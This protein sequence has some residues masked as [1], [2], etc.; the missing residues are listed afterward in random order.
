MRARGKPK[1]TW[2]DG[3]A[4]H[5]PTLRPHPYVEEVRLPD[6]LVEAYMVRLAPGGLFTLRQPMCRDARFDLYYVRHEF[7]Y[8]VAQPWQA[9]NLPS[10]HPR[11]TM[12]VYAGQVRVTEVGRKGDTLRLSRHSFIIDTVRYITTNLYDFEPVL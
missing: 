3:A 5:V 10:D 4:A 9:H 1:V 8:I 12:A 7:P 6:S 11:G 2:K